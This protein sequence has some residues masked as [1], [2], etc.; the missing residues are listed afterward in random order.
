MGSVSSTPE[1]TD[2]P[3][4]PIENQN[5]SLDQSPLSSVIAMDNQGQ[6]DAAIDEVDQNCEINEVIDESCEKCENVNNENRS[7]ISDVS[8]SK[9]DIQNVQRK[10]QTLEEFKEELRIKREKRQSA[11][12]DLRNEIISLRQ[13]LSEEKEINRQLKQAN[14]CSSAEAKRLDTEEIKEDIAAAI[15]ENDEPE[16]NKGNVTLRRELAN[17]QLSLQLANSE[18][19]SLQAELN[20][21]QKQTDTLKEVNAVS[22]KMIQIRE[23]QLNQ[24]REKLKTIEESLA[25]RELSLMSTTLRQEYDRQLANIRNLR[26]LYEER[27][28]VSAAERENLNRQLDTKK[29]E[30]EAET[31]KSKNLSERVATLEADL[32]QTIHKLNST[33]DELSQYKSENRDL[34]EEMKVINEL[35]SQLLMGFNGGNDINIDKLSNMLEDNRDLL[36]DITRREICKD[37]AAALPKL[38]FDL[39][40]Q[41]EE[42][43]TDKDDPSA[44]F[45]NHTE[46][47][48]PGSEESCIPKSNVTTAQE[49]CHNLPKVWK[50]LIELLNHQKAEQVT[51]TENGESEDCYNSVQTPTGPKLVLSV[52]KTYIKLKDLILEKKFLQKETNKL[53]NLNNHLEHRLSHQEKRLG[54]VTIEL[55]KTWSLVG[56]M[57]RQHRQ[58]HTHEQ[59]LRY[60]LQ[61]KR[62]MLNEL[63]EELEYCRR[64]WALAREKN[65]ESQSQWNNL[66]TEFSQRKL[67]D[68]N[69]SGESGYSDEPVSDDDNSDDE[70]AKLHRGHAASP[71]RNE[72]TTSSPPVS[73]FVTQVFQTTSEIVPENLKQASVVSKPVENCD[74][75]YAATSSVV[76]PKTAAKITV[77]NV[78]CSGPST[79]T[80]VKP[81]SGDEARTRLSMELRKK[82]MKS[83]E[84]KNNE[85]TL[86]QM[87]FRLSGQEPPNLEDSV[88]SEQYDEIED[89]KTDEEIL[90]QQTTSAL[91]SD[92]PP[93]REDITS[94]ILSEEDE[95]RRVKR[96]ARFQRLEEQCQQLITQVINNSTRG[97]ELNL[98]L[99]NMQR[100]FTPSRENSKSLDKSDE[101]GATGCSSEA[102]KETTECLS[103][104]EQEYTSRR[105]ERLKRLEE[106]C[107]EFLN[108]QNKSKMRANE[109]SNKLDKLHQRYGS[110][111]RCRET[112]VT[113][114]CDN[115]EIELINEEEEHSNRRVERLKA[116]DDQS[117]ELLDRMAQSTSRANDIERTLDELP[118]EEVPTEPSGSFQLPEECNLLNGNV[119]VVD[120][121]SVSLSNDENSVENE[122]D[123]ETNSAAHNNAN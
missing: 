33:K 41:A 102:S 91:V 92:D 54:A 45:L 86:E 121:V 48:D 88:T 16:Q 95:E 114:N 60:Q 25:D 93:N 85:E 64:K 119:D 59:V 28:R 104:R 6:S 101:E 42:S 120:N 103:Q 98:H 63:K 82:P 23:D 30:L 97:D 13:Q 79:H 72:T 67:E 11:I 89:L 84:K 96:A 10:E 18:I 17:L 117:V 110:Q 111:E 77:K 106:E 26:S 68:A 2:D 71:N 15:N 49:I 112:Q 61:Q 66:R 21:R 55:N 44:S 40:T 12:A 24:M 62:R 1:A 35:F 52:S 105:A 47:I 69:N 37:G 76:E 109:M 78:A 8:D 94:I 46:Q 31:E 56:K 14:G 73:S 100:R 36:N 70:L 74:L 34:H 83:N 5:F 43:G 65:N 22:K 123:E 116:L 7:E 90:L 80:G 20:V 4:W 122:D 51:F 108:K 57:Q 75:N 19:L 113:E 3:W 115:S 32:K 81:K 27:A 50:V 118:V 58:L 99:D 29:A 38:L 87:F 107:K 39:V 9:T 53:K